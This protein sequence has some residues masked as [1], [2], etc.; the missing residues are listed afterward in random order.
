[1]SEVCMCAR[2]L[3]SLFSI[4]VDKALVDYK[5]SHVNNPRETTVLLNG[6][7]LNVNTLS[8]HFDPL[9]IPLVK[10]L[11]STLSYST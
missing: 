2:V 6:F 8:N 5:G 9:K 1:M 4:G 11:G 3:D 10:K 7:E